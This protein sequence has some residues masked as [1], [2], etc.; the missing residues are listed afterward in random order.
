MTRL[1]GK[2][3]VIMGGA[4]GIGRAAAKRLIA[5]DAFVFVFGR[6]Q[7]AFD[8]ALADFGPNAAR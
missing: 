3:A 8:T 5:E 7:E 2:T 1:N 4:T 6:R